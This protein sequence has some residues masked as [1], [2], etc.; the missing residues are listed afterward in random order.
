MKKT[1][2][3]LAFVA[4]TS[5]LLAVSCKKD[6]KTNPPSPA[7]PPPANE[8]ELITTFKLYLSDGNDT[9][10]YMFKDPDGE[11]GIPAFYGPG[12]T[13]A[14]T[15]SDSVIVL[16]PNTSYTATLLFLDESKTVTD[17]ISHEIEEEADEHMVFFNQSNPSALPN[18]SVTISGTNLGI[19]YLDND[20][21]TPPLPLGLISQWQTGNVTGKAPLTIALKH[22]PGSKNG[23]YAPGDT[24]ISVLFKV[25][26]N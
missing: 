3:Q 6:E 11:G 17:T 26:I 4:L 19:T 10:V 1:I 24:D 12:T 13:T 25:L 5:G 2:K 7:P 15:Q 8:E 22:Q 14:S 21:S 20:G 18:A 16:K 23:T 9:T